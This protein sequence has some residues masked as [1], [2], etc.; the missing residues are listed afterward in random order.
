MKKILCIMTCRFAFKGKPHLPQIVMFKGKEYDTEEDNA[1]DGI[2][3][4]VVD[5]ALKK[6]QIELQ[7]DEDVSEPES[8]E[9]GVAQTTP[10]TP[11]TPVVASAPVKPVV[12]SEEDN[13]DE[14][15]FNP[16]T[17]T[18]DELK[19]FVKA[20]EVLDSVLDLRGAEST[21]RATVVAYL[22]D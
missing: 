15:P 12:S 20:D 16:E 22:G 21:I 4:W 1:K 19:E 11:V 8:E 3:A 6:E 10:V 13:D 9:E 14:T 2:P 17:A 5:I 7:Q 18:L